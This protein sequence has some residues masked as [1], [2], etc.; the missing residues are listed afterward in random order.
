MLES[1]VH[2]H[3]KLLL[4]RDSFIWPHNLTLSRLV[5]RSLR[6]HDKSLF[7]LQIDHRDCWWIGLL[8]PICL[9]NSNA[10]I[11]ISER[12]RRRL[13]QVEFPRLMQEGFK[14]SSW[15][16][17]DL[18]PRET[19]WL[20]NHVEFITAFENG[21]LE[22]RQIVFPEAELLSRRLRDAMT[23]KITHENWEQLRRSHPSMDSALLEIYQRVSKK[24]FVQS[25]RENDQITI[26]RSEIISLTDLLTL[27]GP[28]PSPWP[29]LLKAVNQDW[30]SWGK[31]N[32][33]TLDWVWYLQ[34]LEPFHLMQSLFNESSIIMLTGIGP[35]K[36][37]L[38]ELESANCVID[39]SVT[40]GSSVNSD[41]LQL[42]VPLRQPLPNTE[43]YAEYLL[44]QS[45]RLILG[46]LGLTLLV[47]D[48]DQLR[49]KL[50]SQLAAEFGLRVVHETTG[51]QSNG[52]ICCS[53][54]WWINHQDQL[55]PPEQLIIAILPFSSLSSPLISARVDSFKKQGRDWFRELLLPDIL[56]ILPLVVEP[57]RRNSGRL[58]ILDGR[59]RSRSWGK[60][61]FQ[62]LQPWIPL[63]RLLPY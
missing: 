60:C 3:L 36:L 45:R 42:F 14:F 6:R 59:L 40:L 55:P 37:L 48:D 7:Q 22:S 39:V 54:K 27:L 28:C 56:S 31:L 32:H 30:A 35:N 13:L 18:A 34:P 62:V 24:L 47:L 44:D 58:A 41:P 50:T 10:V 53:S 17:S 8:L 43:F 23:I 20:L 33:K 11:V 15:E 5:A 63:E 2:N 1:H 29:Q 51:P 25:T 61:V 38:S 52:V 9:E 49:V 4:K 57:V 16:G 26:Q 46:R 12:Q 19:I 21:Y